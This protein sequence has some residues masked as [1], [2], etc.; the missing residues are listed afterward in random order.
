LRFRFTWLGV[1]A[2]LILPDWSVAADE[3]G[4]LNRLARWNHFDGEGM[5]L[6]VCAL[7]LLIL[8]GV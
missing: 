5:S 8:A 2:S 4:P 6:G 3:F 7:G 1:L